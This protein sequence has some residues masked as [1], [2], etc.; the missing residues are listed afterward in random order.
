MECA[1]ISLDHDTTL[2]YDSPTTY[3]YNCNIPFC[4][5]LIIFLLRASALWRGYNWIKHLNTHSPF[6]PWRSIEYRVSPMFCFVL[7]L[8]FLPLNGKKTRYD[9]HF[10]SLPVKN[11]SSGKRGFVVSH[12]CAKSSTWI[13]II[14]RTVVLRR[15]L[16]C[17]RRHGWWRHGVKLVFIEYW[18]FWSS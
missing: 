5:V 9:Q 1:V 4:L 10:D 3:L 2:L 6:S 17:D 8:E 13:K 12:A 11:S 18:G 16:T 14:V 15:A 7:F